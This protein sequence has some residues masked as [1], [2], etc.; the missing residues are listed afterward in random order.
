MRKQRML[1]TK[2]FAKEVNAAYTTVMG[3]LKDGRIPGAVF[4]DKIP[5]GGIWW[6]PAK[7]VEQFKQAERRRGRPPLVK[8]ESKGPEHRPR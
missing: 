8:K 7:A 3:W 5:R 6:I 4:D 1:T 2:E